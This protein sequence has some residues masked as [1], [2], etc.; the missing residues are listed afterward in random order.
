MTTKKT[1]TDLFAEALYTLC[2]GKFYDYKG[3]PNWYNYLSVLEDIWSADNAD[4]LIAARHNLNDLLRASHKACKAR[5]DRQGR[6]GA[7]LWIEFSE[8]V[9]VLVKM[10]KSELLSMTNQI[11]ESEYQAA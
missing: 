4:D 6:R 11:I 9:E 1:T 3:N 7:Q 5:C 2:G 10:F 8:H